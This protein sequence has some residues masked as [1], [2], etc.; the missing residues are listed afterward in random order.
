MRAIGP[1]AAIL[2]MAAIACTGPVDIYISE[3]RIMA[4]SGENFAAVAME[5]LTFHGL[6]NLPTPTPEA[7]TSTP[8]ALPTPVAE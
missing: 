5:D 7:A 1:I 8:V 3:D 2:I 6:E 4:G